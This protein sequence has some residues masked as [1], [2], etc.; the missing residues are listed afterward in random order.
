MAPQPP[1]RVKLKDGREVDIRPIEPADAEQL[2]EG[3]EALSDES[4]YRRFLTPKRGFSRT[5]LEERA[6]REALRAAAR[7]VLTLV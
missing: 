1:E 2:E 7:G 6:V 3:L 5:E 4:R